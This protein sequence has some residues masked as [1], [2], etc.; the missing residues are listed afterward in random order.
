MSANLGI[1]GIRTG[2]AN[3]HAPAL[4]S[5]TRACVCSARTPNLGAMTDKPKQH[6][7]VPQYL[8]I[9]KKA[10]SYNDPERREINFQKRLWELLDRTGVEFHDDPDTNEASLRG[11]KEGIAEVMAF[12]EKEKQRGW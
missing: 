12:M 5:S 11:T 10:L 2:R 4:G 1:K 7:Q 3:S 9:K 8:D 6:Q